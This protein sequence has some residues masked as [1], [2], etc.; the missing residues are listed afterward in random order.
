LLLSLA[1]CGAAVLATGAG[2]I[3]LGRLQ[4][5]GAAWS[6]PPSP[7]TPTPAPVVAGGDAVQT[8]GIYQVGDVVRNV[9][10]SQVN[11]RQ[12]PGYLGKPDGDVLALVLPGE[13]LEILGGRAQ[14]DNLTWWRIRYA[15]PGGPVIEGW[16]AEATASGVQIL[17]Q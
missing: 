15:S 2:Q 17:G 4:D 3:D 6:P 13:A 14:A 16:V 12:A 8:G 5:S 9:T 1:S 10:S 11:I 7:P